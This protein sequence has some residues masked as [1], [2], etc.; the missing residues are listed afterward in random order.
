MHRV[1]RAT[2]LLAI[3]APLGALAI[4][5]CVE[6]L[7]TPAVAASIEAFTG[8]P[9]SLHM[10]E[11]VVL[12]WRVENALVF[13][14]EQHLGS[15]MP[16]ATQ[17]WTCVREGNS[18]VCTAP[19]VPAS[20]AGWTCGEGE[21]RRPV[22]DDA[23]DYS[24][25]EVPTTAT[26]VGSWEGWPD[27]TTTYRIVAEG[28]AGEPAMAWVQ[29]VITYE[30]EARIDYWFASPT[31]ALVGEVVTFRYHTHKCAQ[32]EP[33]AFPY[34]NDNEF[35]FEGD[36]TNEEGTLTWV[37]DQD[38]DFYLGCRPEGG[39]ASA[40][41]RSHITV[42]VI[43][44][45]EICERIDRFDVTPAGNINPGDTVR[46]EWY[47]NRAYATSVSGRA[48]PAGTTSP[49]FRI[50]TS[51]LEGFWEGRVNAETTFI[52]RAY[53]ACNGAEARHT[54]TMVTDCVPNCPEEYECGDDG[55]GGS[56]GGCTA[57]STCDPVDH[58]CM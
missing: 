15:V 54:V 41:I 50:P 52:I 55:C 18:M 22:T 28:N 11:R 51:T 40:M 38:R 23:E 34:L 33:V 10:S 2:V 46:V 12:R 26:P 56:C 32:I 45:P 30:D 13:R 3:L 58:I 1:I 39:D 29:A 4:A 48:E 53:G 36:Y 16:D 25:I 57:P 8:T 19:V 31:P 7:E 24:T 27:R 17:A 20:A 49:E 6:P 37:A 35:R 43:E 44:T 42:P 14:L 21:C 9:Q 47:V 5:A